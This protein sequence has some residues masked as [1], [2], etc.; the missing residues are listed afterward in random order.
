[1]MKLTKRIKVVTKTKNLIKFAKQPSILHNQADHSFLCTKIQKKGIQTLLHKPIYSSLFSIHYLLNSD[2]CSVHN[3]AFLK[4]APAIPKILFIL[5]AYNFIAYMEC[6]RSYA[7][8]FGHSDPELSSAL[9][10]L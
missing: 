1:M 2:V 5:G 6:I 10:W 9:N 4:S 3:D 8:S 7:W